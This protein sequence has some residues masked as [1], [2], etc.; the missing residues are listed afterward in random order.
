MR[1][2]A[3]CAGLL[4]PGS[5]KGASRRTPGRSRRDVAAMASRLVV[6]LRQLALWGFAGLFAL[7]IIWAVR[8]LR[9]LPMGEVLISGYSGAAHSNRGVRIE[10]LEEIIESYRRQPYWQI[11]LG[12]L[13]RDL[14][15]HTWVRRATL[16]R[17]WPDKIS[18][19][20]DEQVPI[21][22][23]NEKHLLASSGELVSVDEAAL[24]SSL[25]QF[26]VALVQPGNQQAVRAMVGHYNSLQQVLSRQ[27]QRIVELGV[28]E[29]Q[30]VWLVTKGGARIELGREQ[31]LQRLQRLVDFIE[32]GVITSWRVIGRADM[33][34]PAGLSV[35]WVDTE[36]EE[37]LDSLV[38]LVVNLPAGQR[39]GKRFIDRSLIYG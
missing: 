9:A 10:E 16:Y 11:D 24:F 21:A 20:I 22:R 2:L 12:A 7:A 35:D 1:G 33:R 32:G 26:R 14:E 5:R 36:W 17:R 19:G 25:P 18:I 38:P 3:N 30:D 15:A 6:S 28:S 27:H 39:P 8:D 4:R 37:E 13:Q 29:T 34:Y 31:Q 23:W